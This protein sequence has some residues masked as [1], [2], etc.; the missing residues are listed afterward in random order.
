[1]RNARPSGRWRRAGMAAAATT[2]AI[3]LGGVIAGCGSSDDTTTRGSLPAVARSTSSA[4]RPRRPPTRR[5]SSPAFRRPPPGTGVSFSNSFGASG[6]QS[7]AVEAGQPADVV[8]LLARARHD[9]PG[10]RRHRR[11]RLEQEPYNGHRPGLGRVVRRPQGQPEEHQDLGRPDQARTSRSSRRTRSPPA[12]ARWNIMAAYGAQLKEG[13]TP[14]QA[15]AY[16]KH[17]PRQGLRCSRRSARDALAAFTAARATCCS[18]TR[19]RRS[20][21][22]RPARTSTTSSPTTRS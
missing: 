14:A 17:R 19:T 10:R 4:T 12:R 5:A 18:P 2:L 15:Q 6:D 22:R 9:P 20:R 8:A 11:C 13:K 1:M 7:R 21:P 3:G 16:L